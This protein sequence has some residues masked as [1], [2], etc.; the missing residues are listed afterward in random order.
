MAIND[1]QRAYLDQIKA[2]GEATLPANVFAKLRDMGLVTKV[3][4]RTP[5]RCKVV[6]SLTDA[7]RAA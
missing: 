4:G 1:T 5:G 6:A 7:G 3:E 2:S